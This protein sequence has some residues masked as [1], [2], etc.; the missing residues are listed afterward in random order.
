MKPDEVE[1]PPVVTIAQIYDRTVNKVELVKG[2]VKK[3]KFERLPK[4]LQV[5][6]MYEISTGLTPIYNYIP[7]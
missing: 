3:G 7:R 6:M 4:E 2:L 1:L 5:K